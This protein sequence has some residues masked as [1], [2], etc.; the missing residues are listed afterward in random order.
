MTTRTRTSGRATNPSTREAAATYC[1][2][3][4][5]HGQV[6]RGSRGRSGSSSMVA[7]AV[8]RHSRTMEVQ[9]APDVLL[10]DMDNAYKR[11]C[12]GVEEFF[13]TK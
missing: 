11:R 8:A 10:V 13:H 3:F 9:N 1:T 12:G 2:V 5:K 7:V 6:G 4:P